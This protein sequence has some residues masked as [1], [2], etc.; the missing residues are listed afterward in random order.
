MGI[1]HSAED[2]GG[3]N[4]E[5][6]EHRA[7]KVSLVNGLSM[8]L[9]IGSQL[10]SVPVCLHYWGKESY[11]SW[12][13]LFSA[14]MLLRGLDGGYTAFVGNKLNYLY[15]QDTA[16][17]REHLSS[18]VFGIAIIGFLQLVLAAGTLFFDPLSAMLGMSADHTD[19][20][21]AKLG[22]LALMMSWV[23]TG[24]YLGI[25]HRLLI[26]AGLMYQAAWWGMEFQICQFGAI[27][28]A[29][30]LRLNM[31]QTSLVLASSQLASYVASALYVRYKLPGFSPWL[32]GA[33]R[34][35]GLRD[36]GQSVFLTTSNLI[37]QGAINGS[38]LLVSVLAG[39]VAVP[40]FTTVRTLTNLW[41]AV[42]T[43][44]STPL[45]PDVVRIHAKGEVQ[46][47]VAI[48]Q[49]YWVLV[50]SAVNLGAIL[51]YPLIPFLYGQW[52][53]HA[54]VLDNS[55]L[56]LLLG[57]VVVANSGA[58]IA[59]H[60]NGINSLRIVLGASVA[61]AMLGLGGGAL[62]FGRYGLASF[63]MGILAGEIVATLMTARYFLKHEVRAKGSRMS[64][65]DFGPVS[66]ST[67]SV[68]LFF[69]G[70]G[71]GWWSV[72]WVWLLAVG[73]VACA[74]IWGWNTL[75]SDLQSR[76]KGIPVKLLGL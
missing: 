7:A 9:G 2:I 31:L 48:N 65:A 11:G 56:C 49:A 68:L 55:L 4:G 3:L 35:I 6:I 13:A 60:L 10:V 27:M 30:V 28:V 51:S 23:L 44:L 59:L 47:L 42:T 70:A 53:A 39:P 73:G 36:L 52:T 67:G 19:D 5:P 72:G 34:R 58:L 50:G 32:K 57:S 41:T 46:K 22:L 76:L 1:R 20:L 45:L 33:K 29:A 24:S 38:V 8:I 71:V 40:V 16:A 61:R 69:A 17:L 75:E 15:H 26:P 66:L 21:T 54:V 18:A 64:V 43:I 25:V 74:S 62:G 63:G 14:F 37:Q 12:L